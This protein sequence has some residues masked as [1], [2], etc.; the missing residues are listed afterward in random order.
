M[1]FSPPE[2]AISAISGAIFPKGIVSVDACASVVDSFSEDSPEIP[3]C[4]PKAAVTCNS[5]KRERSVIIFEYILY[6]LVVARDSQVAMNRVR[7]MKPFIE[8]KAA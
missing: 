3:G 4:P 5:R 6:Y 2:Y 1:N 7:L 8:K